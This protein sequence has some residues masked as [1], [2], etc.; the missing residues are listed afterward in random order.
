VLLVR[1]FASHTSLWGLLGISQS[2]WS[3][4]GFVPGA[5]PLSFFPAGFGLFS[6]WVLAFSTFGFL[7][8]R[9]GFS[10]KA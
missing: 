3:G 1:W 5:F 7:V 8:A 9:L 2:H 6:G 10:L 4:G